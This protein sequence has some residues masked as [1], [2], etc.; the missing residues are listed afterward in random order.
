MFKQHTWP[1]LGMPVVPTPTHNIA[2]C[3]LLGTIGI[4]DGSSSYRLLDSDKI[5]SWFPR[6]E[7]PPRTWCS[8][9]KLTP[10]VL[11][12]TLSWGQS[13]TGWR[14]LLRTGQRPLSLCQHSRRL[15]QPSLAPGLPPTCSWKVVRMAPRPKPFLCVRPRST[16]KLLQ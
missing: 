9:G 1:L 3:S 2:N 14:G 15:S 4:D 8:C 12:S 10:G 5:F 13:R 16:H 11:W 7:R 6:Q